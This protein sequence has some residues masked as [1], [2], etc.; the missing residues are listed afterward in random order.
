M[1]HIQNGLSVY[2]FA[3]L[4]EEPFVTR[5]AYSGYFLISLQEKAGIAMKQH[6]VKGNC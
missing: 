5:E 6:R 4:L 3:L 2:N 1:G